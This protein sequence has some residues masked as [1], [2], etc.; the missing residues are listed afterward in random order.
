MIDVSDGLAADLGHVATASGVGMHL[1]QIPVAAGAT[2]EEALAGGE[3]FAL[4]FCAPD[5]GAVAAAFAGLGAPLR[6]G[7]CTDEV[8][9]VVFEGRPLEPDGWQHRW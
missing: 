1:D 4:A 3:D 7:T 6:I 5:A 9:Q 2:Q 8:G